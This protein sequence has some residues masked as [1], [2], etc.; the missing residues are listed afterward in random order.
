MKVLRNSNNN[1]ETWI[2]LRAIRICYLNS[3]M[4]SYCHYSHEVSFVLVE[5]VIW[6]YKYTQIW[7]VDHNMGRY[8]QKMV[9]KRTSRKESNDHFSGCQIKVRNFNA[10]LKSNCWRFSHQHEKLNTV[11]LRAHSKLQLFLIHDQMIITMRTLITYWWHCKC[12]GLSV[13]HILCWYLNKKVLYLDGKHF[14]YH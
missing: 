9:W 13:L 12:D 1:Y 11:N 7:F 5:T 4:D 14:Y 3:K 8:M 10:N 2:K 6:R